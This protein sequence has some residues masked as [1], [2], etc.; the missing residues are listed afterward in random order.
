LFRGVSGATAEDVRGSVTREIPPPLAM[1]N[2]RQILDSSEEVSTMRIHLTIDKSL[3]RIEE[4]FYEN[5]GAV[6]AVLNPERSAG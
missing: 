5:T 3:F 2:I 6:V 4:Q 1:A